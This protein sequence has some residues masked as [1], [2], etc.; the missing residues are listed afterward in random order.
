MIGDS[1]S[2][3]RFEALQ[4]FLIELMMGQSDNGLASQVAE[5]VAQIRHSM[6]NPDT[7]SPGP[8]KKMP[9]PRCYGLEKG[10]R[11]CFVSDHSRYLGTGGVWKG[12]GNKQGEGGDTP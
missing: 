12:I 9:I 6:P 5:Y 2:E 8:R 7:D 10:T 3:Q 1:L 11:M 4:C